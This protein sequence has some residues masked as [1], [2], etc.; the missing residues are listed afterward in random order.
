MMQNR[1]VRMKSALP[2][3]ERFVVP[4]AAYAALRSYASTQSDPAGSAEAAFLALLVTGMLTMIAA[5]GTGRDGEEPLRV[6]ELAVTALLA[7][8]TVWIAYQGPSRGAVVSLILVVGL[9]M[10]AARVLLDR[11]GRLRSDRALDPGVTVPLALGLQLLMRGDLLLA[12][13]LEPRTLVSL[14]A[15]PLVAGVATS[16]L[17]GSLGRRRALLA[18][19]LTVVLAPGWT[20][21]STLA[22]AAL[23]AGAMIADAKRPRILRWA[24]VAALAVLPFWSFPAGLLFVAGALALAAPSTLTASLLPIAVLVVVFVAPKGGVGNIFT[25]APGAIEALRTWVGAVLLV[26][27]A[28]IAENKRRWQVRLGVILILAAALV[29]PAPEATAAG[30]A[31]AALAVP[32]G[33][34]VASLQRAWCAALVLGTALLAGYPWVRD[35][36]RGDLVALLGFESEVTAFLI[37]LMLV[38]GLGLAIDQSRARI[39]AWALHPG[40]LACLL[41]GLGLARQ[42]VSIVETNVLVNSYQPVALAAGNESWQRDLPAGVISGVAIDSHLAGGI[43]LGSGTEAAVVELLAGDGS[44][45]AEW[46][47]RTGYETGEW[48]ASRP[49]LAGKWGFVAPSPW[50]SLV[51]PGGGFFAHR[52]RARFTVSPAAATEADRIQVRRGDGLPAATRLS[53]YRLELRR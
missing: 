44:V 49:D 37:L 39:P 12:P 22:V 47:L 15:L 24:A 14:L 29:S 53:I 38:V 51:A 33:G 45:L 1:S 11:Q 46:P 3:P 16:L 19:G 32:V 48:A 27:G 30:V 17:A 2:E 4:L 20:M 18:C 9:A 42:A 7:T 40:W 36:P 13:P 10:R 31:L 41:L 28:I 8:A 23:A 6:D 26:P 21:T 50:L 25:R 5:L 52:Y 35:D 43:P 34:A